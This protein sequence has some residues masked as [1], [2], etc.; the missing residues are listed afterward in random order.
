MKNQNLILLAV[1][2]ITS[3]FSV[4]AGCS[5]RQPTPDPVAKSA[6]I[7][8]APLEATVPSRTAVAGGV[9]TTT[10]AT[11]ADATPDLFATTAATLEK[12]TREQV[13]ELTALPDQ[14]SRMIDSTIASWKAKGGNSNSM[15]ESKLELARTDFTQKVRTLTLAGEDTWTSAKTDAQSSLAFAVS[16]TTPIGTGGS[17]IVISGPD[18]WSAHISLHPR[19]GSSPGIFTPDRVI[20]EFAW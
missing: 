20:G 16:S 5:E 17:A 11:G 9:V 14:V 19:R 7:N 8:P 6:A 10:V 3:L 4:T 13:A 15:S 12:S 18:P 2:S 1:V